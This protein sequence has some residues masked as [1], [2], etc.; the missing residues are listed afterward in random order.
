MSVNERASHRR[1]EARAPAGPKG[2]SRSMT[3]LRDL[4][5]RPS[6]EVLT[7]PADPPERHGRRHARGS[8]RDG[9]AECLD[10][11]GVTTKFRAWRL[12]A[13]VVILAGH[14]SSG[15]GTGPRPAGGARGPRARPRPRSGREGQAGGG[16]ARPA[17]HGPPPGLRRRDR[18]IPHQ[19]P[20]QVPGRP[21]PHGRGRRRRGHPG[22]A[23]WTTTNTGTRS[24]T[25]SSASR[26]CAWS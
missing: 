3:S 15:P 17:D 8:R 18:T 24:P 21:Q 16:D 12:L 13:V 7:G 9:P 10:D 20:A 5:R 11:D 1:R 25:S 26:A 23:G 2:P 19:V 4:P 6:S 14:G 22:R